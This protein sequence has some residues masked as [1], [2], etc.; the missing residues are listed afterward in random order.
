MLR[1]IA[2]AT[3]A[4]ISLAAGPGR[5]DINAAFGNTV[6]SRYP[7]G[8]WVKHWFNPDGSY[9]AQFSDGRRLAA[10]WSVRGERVCL[11]NIRPNMLIPRFC[12]DMIQADVGDSW[13]SRD[14]LGRRVQNV[15]VAGRQ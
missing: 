6:V 7:D 2:V 12:T 1:A 5:T 14:P 3:V 13:Q 8:G 9:A 4:V 15:L 10:R 11:T